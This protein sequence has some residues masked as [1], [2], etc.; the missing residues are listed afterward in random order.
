MRKTRIATLGAVAASVA[1]IASAGPA[2]AD[3]THA[4]VKEKVVGPGSVIHATVTGCGADSM[5]HFTTPFSGTGHWTYADGTWHGMAK[6]KK[7]GIM[8]EHPKTKTSVGIQCSGNGPVDVPVVYDPDHTGSGDEPTPNPTHPTDEP[9]A[10]PSHK[11]SAEPSHTTTAQPTQ[12]PQM[13]VKIRPKHFRAGD[14]LHIS[15]SQCTHKPTVNSKIFAGSAHWTQKSGIWRTP[16]T[17]AKNIRT[18]YYKLTVSCKGFNDAA[19]K[20]RVGQPSGGD[21]NGG[22]DNGGHDNGNGN[23]NGGQNAKP[24]KHTPNGQ[25]KV[26]P[27]GGASTGGGSTAASFV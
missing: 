5:P 21:D 14:T 16:V 3:T 9:T 7:W 17:T 15:V 10:Q 1:M 18:G 24:A 20:V 13:H 4:S 11:P 26:I 2:F 27:N 25:T 19:F 23:D 12:Q 8:H 22:H 6:V